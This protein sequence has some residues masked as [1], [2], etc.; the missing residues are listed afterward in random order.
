MSF[1]GIQRGTCVP[2]H[3][4]VPVHDL[5]FALESLFAAEGRS[6]PFFFRYNDNSYTDS[7]LCLI[8]RDQQHS[9]QNKH[10]NSANIT[11]SSRVSTAQTGFTAQPCIHAERKL[12]ASSFT[13]G[14]DI[15]GYLYTSQWKGDPGRYG[16]PK[17]GA[18]MWRW[19]SHLRRSLRHQPGLCLGTHRHAC[20]SLQPA[21]SAVSAV[22]AA[23]CTCLRSKESGGRQHIATGHSRV[24]GQV[25]WCSVWCTMLVAEVV[26]SGSHTI[27]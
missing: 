23:G 10:P 1:K 13:V 14:D 6:C 7:C 27:K 5:I 21:R 2:L 11:N 12:V 3:I 15:K 17:V 24:L 19:P 20:C 26:L 18:G 22:E 25:C 4:R 8:A 16:L 9:A